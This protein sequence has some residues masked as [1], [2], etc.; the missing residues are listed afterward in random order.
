M[1]QVKVALLKGTWVEINIRPSSWRTHLG[2]DPKVSSEA[3]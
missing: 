3:H 1:L 2:H